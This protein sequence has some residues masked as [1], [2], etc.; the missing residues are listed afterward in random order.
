L[1][2]EVEHG[3]TYLR[4]QFRIFALEYL[5]YSKFSLPPFLMHEATEY[6]PCCLSNEISRLV[7][8]FA[9]KSIARLPVSVI[10]GISPEKARFE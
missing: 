1:N 10:F 9:K 4:E 2:G 6:S 7:G 3:T 5:K 8:I